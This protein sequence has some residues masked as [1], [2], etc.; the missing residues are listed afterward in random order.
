MS[1]PALA[2]A[3]ETSTN[4]QTLTIILF[5]VFVAVTLG[6][7]IW[8]SRQNRTAADFYAGGRSFTGLQNG[9]G[10]RRRLH[11]GGLVPRNR[12][13]DRPERLRRIPLLDRIPGRLAG[14]AHAGSR[15][16]AEHRQIHHGRRAQLPDAAAAG[17]DGG[18]DLDGRGVDLLPDRPDGRC[19]RPG[20]V[21]ARDHLVGGQEH[22]HRAGRRA[23]DRLRGVRRHEGDHLGADREGRHADGRRGRHD[24]L[25]AGQVRFQ[26]LG[27]ARCGR[28]EVRQGRRVP[29]T[30]CPL[31]VLD[32][33]PEAGLHLARPGPWCWARPACRTS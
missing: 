6:I 28:G 3:A 2:A 17:P 31:R 29:G 25:G 19:R 14:G 7:T 11:V 26:H 21:A 30:R 22:H 9:A 4:H 24:G 23:D 33:D 18:I 12:R 5:A 15:A 20:L 16:D 1:T 8:A 27:P 10:D 32:D 13:S